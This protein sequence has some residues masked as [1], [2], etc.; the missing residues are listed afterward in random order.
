MVYEMDE[1]AK[2]AAC[3]AKVAAQSTRAMKYVEAIGPTA[4][5]PTAGP[6]AF[7]DDDLFG[8]ST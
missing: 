2:K 3:D 5:V 6:P 4:V 8:A 1:A 7:L